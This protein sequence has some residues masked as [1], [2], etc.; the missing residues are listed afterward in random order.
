MEYTLQ[1][2]GIKG[3]RWG[4]R[5]FQNEDGSRTAEGKKRYGSDEKKQKPKK[6]KEDISTMTDD[7]LRQRINRLNLEK[8]YNDAMKPKANRQNGAQY[9]DRVLKTTGSIIATAS[10]AIGLYLLIKKVAP[11][12]SIADTISKLKTKK[13][14]LWLL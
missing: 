9:V 13:D 4:I 6:Q 7:Q 10:S 5:R 11:D 8:Q 3:Q 1:H 2:H 12:F 14:E